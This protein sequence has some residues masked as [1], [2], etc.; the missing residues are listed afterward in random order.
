[1]SNS[2]KSIVIISSRRKTL[3]SV[4]VDMRPRFTP[5]APPPPPLHLYICTVPAS[6]SSGSRVVV[7]PYPCTYSNPIHPLP[8][9]DVFPMSR[10][11]WARLIPVGPPWLALVSFVLCSG[12]T[13]LSFFSAP[14]K[15]SRCRG[16][17]CYCTCCIIVLYVSHLGRFC[18]SGSPLLFLFCCVIDALTVCC[19]RPTDGKVS[20]VY[21]LRS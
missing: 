14:G 9:G 15:K 12:K 19:Y 2:D 4:I 7:R 18:H 5:P 21:H 1:M 13:T 10:L 6:P 20:V 17:G 11:G 3:L 8:P 16:L